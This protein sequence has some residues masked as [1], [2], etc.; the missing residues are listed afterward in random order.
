[1]L[2]RK[3]RLTPNRAL[4]V[5]STVQREIIQEMGGPLKKVQAVDGKLKSCL[6]GLM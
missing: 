2:M 1:M 6:S 5:T 3:L 4:H